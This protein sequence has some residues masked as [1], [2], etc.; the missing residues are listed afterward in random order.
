MG[1][2]KRAL[3]HAN[4]GLVRFPDLG[5]S[6]LDPLQLGVPIFKQVGIKGTI[7]LGKTGRVA[8]AS[9][10]PW[11]DSRGGP[12]VSCAAVSATRLA[13]CGE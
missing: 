6:A 10:A 8:Y 12:R 11:E 4:F 2:F 3:A 13:I 5:Y 1:P 9:R 7:V